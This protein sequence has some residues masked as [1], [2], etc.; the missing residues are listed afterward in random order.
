MN[1]NWLEAGVSISLKQLECWSVNIL[2]WS[3]NIGGDYALA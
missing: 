3:V 1:L 2:P